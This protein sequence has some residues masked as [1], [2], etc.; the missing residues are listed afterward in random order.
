M[1]TNSKY[2]IWTA[3]QLGIIAAMFITA[4]VRWSSVPDRLPIHWN[5]SGEVDGYGGKFVG[6]LLIPLLAI[7]IFVLLAAIPRLDP[8]RANYASFRGTYAVI[9][10]GI[11]ALLGFVYLL[12]NLSINNEDGLPMDSLVLGSAAVLLIGLGAML[13]KVRP[14]YFVGIRTPWTLT[15]KKSWIKTHRIGGWVFILAGAAAGIGAIF[16]GIAGF[17]A[18]FAVLGPGIVFLMVYSYRVWR[19]DP[20]RVSAYETK[21]GPNGAAG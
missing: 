8:A 3:L 5:V 17:I 20:D 18:M 13:G 21:P 19:E 2:K 4:A 1:Q 7:G 12:M 6:L 9:R 14:N 15:S 16:S 10:T 11:V